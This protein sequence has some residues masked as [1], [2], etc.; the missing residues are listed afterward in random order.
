MKK[1]TFFTAF[2]GL[3][4]SAATANAGT[5][6][7]DD[8]MGQLWAGD[9]TT[10]TY[11]YVGTS[12]IAAGFG[13]FTDIDF[14]SNG[15]LYGLDPSGNLYQIDPT[16]GQI[17]A[18]LGS[19]GITDGSLVGLAG[20]SSG[21]LWA[22]GT[23]NVYEINPSVSA[24]ATVVGTGG[25]GYQTEGDLDFDGS[26][27]L[28][29]TST[30]PSGG[31]L[32]QIN[33]TT[34]AGT[35]AGQLEDGM[36][37]PFTDVFGVAYDSDNGVFYGYDVSGNQFDINTASPSSSGTGEVIFT[38]TGA[39]TPDVGGILG[40]AFIASATPEP[41]TFGLALLGG[42]LILI[43]VRRRRKANQAV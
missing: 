22:G 27:N 43:G 19:T 35:Y 16:T 24:A 26:G 33:T 13:G 3:A 7:L 17:I 18:S 31:A 32:Y 21:N 12:A 5:V 28:W 9:P 10:G 39:G 41:S 34:G 4:M 2:A 6:Y 1:V 30:S 36:G 42:G 11:A 8:N 37:D 38:E 40:A 20:D 29:L 23:N 25:G 14:T 15:N